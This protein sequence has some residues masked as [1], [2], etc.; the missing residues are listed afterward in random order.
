MQLC[1]QLCINLQ[2]SL[3]ASSFVKVRPSHSCLS[4]GDDFPWCTDIF[5]RS[6]KMSEGEIF[7]Q[8][9]I[10]QLD[11]VSTLGFD[12]ALNHK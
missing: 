2:F 1:P 12:S 3:I 7:L 9:E 8:C 11:T 10:S 4:V 6:C 5:S